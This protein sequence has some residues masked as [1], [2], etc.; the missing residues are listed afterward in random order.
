MAHY[1]LVFSIISLFYLL[2]IPSAIKVLS[3]KDR[4]KFKQLMTSSKT[5]KRYF[6]RIMIVGKEAVGK[7]CLLKRLLKESIFGV[8][9]TDGVE[10]IVRHCKINIQDGK[11]IIGKGMYIFIYYT[12][13]YPF[14]LFICVVDGCIIT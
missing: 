4:N 1:I 2:D 13:Q 7:T 14:P 12:I 9:S 8:K 5:E 10:I 3:E 6:L 11:W